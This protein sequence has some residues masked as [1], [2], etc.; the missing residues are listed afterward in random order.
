MKNQQTKPQ[1]QSKK[2]VPD[3]LPI[4]DKETV[5]G[6]VKPISWTEE[7]E[8]IES[9]HRVYGPKH[10]Y[11]DLQIAIALTFGWIIG[12]AILFTGLLILI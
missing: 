7:Y 6:A 12:L 2:K 5:L 9:R 3:L 10:N 4:P 11:S 1:K 8:E